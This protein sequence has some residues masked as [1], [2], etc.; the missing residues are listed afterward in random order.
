MIQLAAVALAA[1][2][3]WGMVV[4]EF[5]NMMAGSSGGSS[6]SSYV[7]PLPYAGMAG[8]S[9]SSA[10]SFVLRIFLGILMVGVASNLLRKLRFGDPLDI[11]QTFR[12]GFS[13]AVPAGIYTLVTGFMLYIA[14][15]CCCILP[16]IWLYAAVQ[17]G[18]FRLADGSPDF[19]MAFTDG[20]AVA[21][22]D[23]M[24][25]FFLVIL[26]SLA[27]AIGVFGCIIG[28]FWT[29]PI[30]YIVFALAYRASF[31]TA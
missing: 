27:A 7:P 25:Y 4:A 19:W 5:A 1:A 3:Q 23:I 29:A 16:G 13:R 8:Q 31:D 28:V 14:S 17:L 26:S 24:G 30:S 10:L 9:L 2:P 12:D 20:L 21:Q 11:G 18:Y 15:S 6:S 22:S